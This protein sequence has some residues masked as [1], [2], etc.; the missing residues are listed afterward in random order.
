[1][2][3]VIRPAV[4]SDAVAVARL[5]AELMGPDAWSESAVR[6][7]LTGPLRCAIVADHVSDRGRARLVGCAVLLV[8]GD[9]A[10]LQRIV[11]AR[12][13][14]RRGIAGRLL[15]RVLEE[16]GDEVRRVLLEVRADNAD[17]VG[18]YL[19]NGF[20]EIARRT[21]YYADGADAIVMQRPLGPGA[22]YAGG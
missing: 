13:H 22:Q 10:D 20:T 19:R 21:A 15:G 18:F 5:E 3:I 8:V 14:Q 17:G 6:D 11:V 4:V 9:T 2:S 16:V 7:E 1:M 12:S